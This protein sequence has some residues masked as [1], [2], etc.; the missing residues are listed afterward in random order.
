MITLSING[1]FFGRR[2]TGVDR[3]AIEVIR[4]IDKLLESKDV[5]VVVRIL[6]PPGT[7]VAAEFK[8]IEVQEVGLGRGQFWEQF[9]LPRVLGKTDVLLSLCNTAPIFVRKQI[10][11]IHDAATAKIPSA[12]SWKFR[13]WYKV[14]MPLLGA[15]ASKII[16]V[17][18]FSQ[19]EICSAYRIPTQK[20]SVVL[21][22]A[23]HILRVASDNGVIDRFGLRD[24]PYVL[25]VSSMAHHKNFRLVL[26]SLPYLKNCNFD[27]VIAGGANPKVFGG[28]G[29]ADLGGVKWVGYVSDEELRALYSNALCFVFPSLYEGFGI[30]PLEAMT[31]GCPVIASHAGSIPEVCGGAALYFDPLDAE[32]F[33]RLLRKVCEDADLRASLIEMGEA[34]AKSF[35]WESAARRIL[36]V[37]SEVKL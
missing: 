33:A 20:V 35:S 16:T 21:E 28:I 14:L 32:G 18:K 23:E 37:C 2:L 7:T 34:H 11:V 24:R 10:V 12:F 22:G 25:A 27:I 6:V 17:S 31:C 13:A 30:P 9:S 26:A 15:V 19:R 8:C 5:D 36:R 3:F 1:R 29:G 4:A